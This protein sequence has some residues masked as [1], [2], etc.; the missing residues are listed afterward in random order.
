MPRYEHYLS[1]LRQSSQPAVIIGLALETR[2]VPSEVVPNEVNLELVRWYGNVRV[3]EGNAYRDGIVCRSNNVSG[4]WKSL[5]HHS[6]GVRD[7]FILSHKTGEVWPLL[8]VYEKLESGEITLGANHGLEQQDY[9][10]VSELQRISNANDQHGPKG[11]C[12][13]SLPEMP[14]SHNHGRKGPAKRTGCFAS[15]AA[16]GFIVVEDPPNIIQFRIPGLACKFTWVDIRNYG[17]DIL[18]GP[19]VGAGRARSL[20]DLL[21][22]WV[23]RLASN[24]WGSLR[25][26]G[27]S[28]ALSVFRTGFIRD[29]I[30]CHNTQSALDLEER[31][32]VGGRCEAFRIGAIHEAVY[33][34]DVRSM[35]PALYIA[36][37]L[38]VRLA[39]VIRDRPITLVECS[40]IAGQIIADVLIA[41][42]E[43]AYPV[44]RDG[45][46]IY[47]IGIFR[48]T[49]CGPELSDAIDRQRIIRV[50]SYSHYEFEP[51]LRRFGVELYENRCEA[52]RQ[53]DESGSLFA[54]GLLNAIVGKMGQREK[55]WINR[56]ERQADKPYG[57]WYETGPHGE[58]VRWRSIAW[59]VQSEYCG[60]WANDAVPA[61]ASW[62]TSLGRLRLLSYV[63]TAGKSEVFYIDTDALLVSQ[64]GFRRLND[65]NLVKESHLGSLRL[66]ATSDDCEVFGIKHYRLNG[67]TKRA[68]LPKNFTQCDHEGVKFEVR[69][70]AL[71]D[72]MAQTRPNASIK[73]VTVRTSGAYRHGL[74]GSDGTVSPHTL[75][76][77]EDL[78]RAS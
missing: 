71:H 45:I 76:E 64:L 63:R 33:H 32:Y 73:T 41:T 75:N 6:R 78:A 10:K 50:Y 60:Q 14:A 65:C 17:H 54:K 37:E 36:N 13:N 9:A 66:L 72:T 77:G 22:S 28:Q 49:L 44:N 16:G 20:A 61:M 48:T 59:N 24:A 11:P 42:D 62:V 30:Y 21:V 23:E 4:F 25:A 35:Y 51:V 74:V 40:R 58:L 15:L 52:D 68:G 53:N 18:G 47:P 27:A 70:S 31:S 12:G 26:T 55:R 46:V 57:Y 29:A 8:G 3:K 2:P 39:Q 7:C 67:V 5:A 19:L 43:P 69:S 1:S 34:I 56:P 38:P